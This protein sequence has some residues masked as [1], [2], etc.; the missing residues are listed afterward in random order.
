MPHE[1]WWD[2]PGYHFT[3]SARNILET[4]GS[5]R[6][7]DSSYGATT[8]IG[9]RTVLSELTIDDGR[10]Y[11]ATA[12][13]V[14]AE[15]AGASDFQL[16]DAI[17]DGYASTSGS[18]DADME[19]LTMDFVRLREWRTDRWLLS[20]GSWTAVDP[21]RHLGIQAIDQLSDDYKS[22]IERLV[23]RN[24]RE[25]RHAIR[26]LAAAP[27]TYHTAMSGILTNNTHQTAIEGNTRSK[28]GLSSL[29]E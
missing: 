16:K 12:S 10:S 26:S 21:S 22:R 4:H 13:T 9:P 11:T 28:V 24:L 2:K 20:E 7:D 29:Q 18:N 17:D 19:A 5:V 25:R 6:S 27:S 1:S 3:K 14:V 23:H 8:V 15:R